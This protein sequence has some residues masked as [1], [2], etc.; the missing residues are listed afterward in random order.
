[1][2]LSLEELMR[3]KDAQA[4]LAGAAKLVRQGWCR[5]AY[6]RDALGRK[7]KDPLSDKASAWSA[8]GAIKRSVG[9]SYSRSTGQ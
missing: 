9:N 8:L 3:R 1:M 7:I 5:E 6:A 4:A 2:L